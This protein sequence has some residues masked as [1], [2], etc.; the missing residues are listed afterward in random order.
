MAILPYSIILLRILCVAAAREK[1]AKKN[2]SLIPLCVLYRL[3]TQT[4]KTRRMNKKQNETKA[5]KKMFPNSF[6]AY[7]NENCMFYIFRPFLRECVT[8][9]YLSLNIFSYGN[10]EPKQLRSNSSH[11]RY[12]YYTVLVYRHS[13]IN[14]IFCSTIVLCS[15]FY[16]VLLLFLYIV[17]V[18]IFRWS[19]LIKKKSHPLQ[20]LFTK[21]YCSYVFSQKSIHIILRSN[22]KSWMC[23]FVLLLFLAW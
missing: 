12:V 5:A 23:F 8:W 16:Y 1:K 4:K 9:V 10:K 3:Q 17:N 13:R 18:Y 7:K 14:F 20:V 21:I 11:I 15:L 6:R 19:I 22:C 2:D